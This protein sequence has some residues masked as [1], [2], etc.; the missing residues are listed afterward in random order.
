MINEL[1]IVKTGE[2]GKKFIMSDDDWEPVC[3]V[4]ETRQDVPDGMIAYLDRFG[5]LCFDSCEESI[6]KE[7]ASNKSVSNLEKEREKFQPLVDAAK[8]FVDRCERREIRSVCTY[9]KLKDI[10]KNIEGEP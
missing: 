9:N 4:P 10:L 2:D 6:L 8:E 5:M 7:M 1:G 3:D